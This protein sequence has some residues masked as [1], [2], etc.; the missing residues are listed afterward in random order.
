MATVRWSKTP[1]TGSLNAAAA[2]YLCGVGL[3]KGRY[4]AAQGRKVAADGRVVCVQ[5]DDGAVWVAGKTVT[6]ARRAE[7]VTWE[8]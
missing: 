6:V 4:V 2:Q 1:V 8:T 5:A 7:L 3:A